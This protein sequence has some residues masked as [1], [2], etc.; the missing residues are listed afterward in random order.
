MS[1]WFVV[2]DGIFCD[3]IGGLAAFEERLAGFKKV[4]VILGKFQGGIA[5]R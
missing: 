4:L 2:S 5:R 3:R 1:V